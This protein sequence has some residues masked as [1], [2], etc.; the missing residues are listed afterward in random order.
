M[1]VEPRDLVIVE[2][3]YSARPELAPLIDVRVLV[4]LDE[5][6]RWQR[7][8][9]RAG[10]T[11]RH[12]PSAWDARWDAAEGVYFDT[13]RPEHKFDLVIDGQA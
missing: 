4:V 12:G 13:E 10:G 1:I 9:R 5:T 8:D 7:L 2:G 11:D 3:D 6:E